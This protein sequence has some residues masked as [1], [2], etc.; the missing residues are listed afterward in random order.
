VDPNP[1]SAL[2]EEAGKLLLEDYPAYCSHAKLFTEV[3]AMKP[4]PLVIPPKSPVKSAPIVSTESPPRRSTSRSSTTPFASS[5]AQ[6]APSEGTETKR[7]LL[8]LGIGLKKAEEEDA[9]NRPSKRKLGVRR[10]GK[11][12]LRRL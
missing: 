4:K 8:L 12:G 2:N 1:T 9:E 10:A 7:K 11:G 3:H 5:Q 6:N